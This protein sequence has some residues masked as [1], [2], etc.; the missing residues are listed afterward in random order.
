MGNNFKFYTENYIN[1]RCTFSFTSATNSLSNRLYDNSRDLKLI[2]LGSNDTTDEVWTITFPYQ[3]DIDTIFIDNHNIKSGNLQYWNGS[4]FVDF[5]TPISWSGN[6]ATTNIFSFTSVGISIIKL[7]MSTTQAANAQKYV[8]ELR[9]MALIGE[10]Q[11][12]PSSITDLTFYKKQ[13][14]KET[15]NGGNCQ[16]IFGKKFKMTALFDHANPTDITL[17]ETLNDRLNSFYLHPCGGI[18]TYTEPGF[19]L[20]DMYFVNFVNDFKPLIRGDVLGIGSQIEVSFW[21]T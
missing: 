6:I 2:S 21:E 3:V 5:S 19:R 9:C 20:Q 15:S 8:G 10:M 1:N 14:L 4:A 7:T 13:V 17:L 11:E 18:T 12:N 16:T